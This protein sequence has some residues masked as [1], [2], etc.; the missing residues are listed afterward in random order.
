MI[1]SLPIV[2]PVLLCVGICGCLVYRANK[3]V[4]SFCLAAPVRTDEAGAAQADAV[5]DGVG[6]DL[7]DL[8]LSSA[9]WEDGAQ[10]ASEPAPQDRSTNNTEI[11]HAAPA[12]T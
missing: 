12:A 2:V 1:D 10:S 6:L 11:E 9:E 3:A 8:A 7:P 4:D 5:A